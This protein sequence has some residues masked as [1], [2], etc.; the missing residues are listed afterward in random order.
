MDAVLAALVKVVLVDPHDGPVH[1]SFAKMG[2]T[3]PVQLL[4]A[5]DSFVD[6][7]SYDDNGTTKDLDLMQKKQIKYL[8]DLLSEQWR[9]TPNEQAFYT[10]KVLNSFEGKSGY[11]KSRNCNYF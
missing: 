2:I 5:N 8:R 4:L 6:L 1:K 3:Q 7:M 9:C 11:L 10:S